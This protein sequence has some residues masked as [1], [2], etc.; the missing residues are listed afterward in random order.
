MTVLSRAL[1]LAPAG[2]HLS[3]R[4]PLGTVIVLFGV[5]LLVL[6]AT[7]ALLRVHRNDKQT[8]SGE[9]GIARVIGRFPPLTRQLPLPETSP[10][11]DGTRLDEKAEVV[12]RKAH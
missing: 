12:E 4:F 9:A 1:E 2:A 8:E 5:A 3:S 6:V 10:V 11:R 7:T